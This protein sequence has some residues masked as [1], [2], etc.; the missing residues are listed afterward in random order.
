MSSVVSSLFSALRQLLH[1]CK[2]NKLVSPGATNQF[3]RLSLEVLEC[4]Q[5]G[6]DV[7]RSKPRDNS[8]FHPAFGQ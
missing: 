6:K 8:E 7:S 1:G 3:A 2:W 5:K 4:N